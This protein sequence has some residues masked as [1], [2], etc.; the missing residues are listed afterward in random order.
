MQVFYMF[1]SCVIFQIEEILITCEFWLMVTIG[2]RILI[3]ELDR[4]VRLFESET[5]NFDW[6][7]VIR[8]KRICPLT[9]CIHFLECPQIRD[10]VAFVSFSFLPYL[11]GDHCS[12]SRTTSLLTFVFRLQQDYIHSFII[13]IKYL[14]RVS[15]S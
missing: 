4:G 1:I 10:F 15:F 2:K 11:A 3:P 13:S 14:I 9:S 12:F 7:T 6:W 5:Y 8:G